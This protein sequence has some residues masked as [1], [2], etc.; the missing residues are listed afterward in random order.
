MMVFNINTFQLHTAKNRNSNF[1]YINF[2]PE[3]FVDFF[4]CVFSDFRLYYRQRK[5]NPE[6]QEQQE[7]YQYGS[8]QYFSKFFD[9]RSIYINFVGATM[10]LSVL[11]SKSKTFCVLFFNK[12]KII[13][14]FL[15]FTQI[16]C[17]FYDK[18]ANLYPCHRKFL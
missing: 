16:S 4:R 1:V 8:E 13:Q 7:Q 11:T 2:C 12:S 14:S 6:K 9:T 5:C 15:I 3:I 18:I 17:L 10:K